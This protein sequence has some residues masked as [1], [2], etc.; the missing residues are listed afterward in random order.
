MRGCLRAY[1]NGHLSR[2]GFF[3]R[4]L[5]AGC[6]A[7]AAES[8]VS[9]ASRR[10]LVTPDQ[11]AST[12]SGA[13]Q[14]G[15]GARGDDHT[16]IAQVRLRGR[17][18]LWNVGLRSGRIERI[19]QGPIPGTNTIFAEGRLLTEG[20]VEHHI[21]LDKTLTADRV[22]WD[23][24]SLAADRQKWEAERKAGTFIRGLS[25]WRESQLKHS[26]TEDDVFERAMR[27]AKMESAN[28]STAI[29]TNVV[30]ERVRE[31]KCVRGLIRARDAMRP[32]VD[33]Q[34]NVHPQD[35]NL[36]DEPHVI[37]LC[38]RA[39]KL[40]CNGMGG[41]PEVVPDRADEYIELVFRLAKEYGGFVDIHVDQARDERVFSHP[42][43]VAKTRKYGLQGQ[44]T[45][46]HSYS[47]GYQPR[48]KVLPVLDQMRDVAMHLACTPN[49][50]LEERVQI[51]RSKGILVSLMND[52]V[53]DTWTRGG[54]ADL[55]E[56]GALYYRAMGIS[57]NE[58]L[59]EVF[60]M[61]T[62]FPA[63]ATGLKD[64]GVHEG[65]RA[66]LVLFDAPSAPEVLL[67]KAERTLVFKNGKVVAQAGRTL[68]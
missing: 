32:Y 48:E 12:A 61:I 21:H 57:N 5:A 51:P 36:I 42:I 35:G 50:A 22:Q 17:T 37:D 33:L 28:G 8:L 68:W 47:L 14:S 55:V 1:V 3:E 52:N 27:L 45:A 24:K 34:I 7:A 60:D 6:T 29:R 13:G 31:L 49:R 66:D 15:A 39:M 26:F 62:T 41:V 67:Q 65:A 59:E 2:R 40:G 10:E 53:R 23:E 54:N 19:S 9:A 64:H 18:G 46:S 20:L 16:V 4:M 44:V 63:K 11:L 30:V 43:M 38:H 25:A 56:S 58:G